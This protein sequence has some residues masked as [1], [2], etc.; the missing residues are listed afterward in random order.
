M[1]EPRIV[2][3]SLI[4]VCALIFLSGWLGI[5][6]QPAE[7]QQTVTLSGRVTDFAG[8]AVSGGYVF[9]DRLPGGIFAGEQYTERNGAYRFSVPPG[10]YQLFLSA[11]QLSRPEP[12]AHRTAATKK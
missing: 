5:V 6:V 11:A 9:L 3:C 1:H 10:R 12:S 8:R 4:L 7:A 2:L